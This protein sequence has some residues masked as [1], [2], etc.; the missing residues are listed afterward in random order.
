MNTT[1]TQKEW[2]GKNIIITKEGKRVRRAIRHVG[3]GIDSHII[4]KGKRCEIESVYDN[5]IPNSVW[6]IIS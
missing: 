5:D 2:D 3:Q 6:K 1:N 4:Y